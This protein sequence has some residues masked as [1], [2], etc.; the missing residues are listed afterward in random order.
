MTMQGPLNVKGVTHVL[1]T[2]ILLIRKRLPFYVTH[3]FFII[4]RLC[5]NN[6]RRM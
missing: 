1:Q 2:S 5:L 3:Y 6:R 4:I